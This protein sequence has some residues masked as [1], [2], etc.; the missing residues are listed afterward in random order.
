MQPGGPTVVLVV[1]LGRFHGVAAY[2]MDRIDRIDR[3]K[4]K[5]Q[6]KTD[7]R[8]IQRP[9]LFLFTLPLSL[10]SFSCSCSPAL[11][12]LGEGGSSVGPTA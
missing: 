8:P 9:G 6:I 4:P 7:Q 11:R 3:M 10:Y 1:I 2:R 5:A 12:S